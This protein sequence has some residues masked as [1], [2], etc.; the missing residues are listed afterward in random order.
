MARSEMEEVKRQTPEYSL[1]SNM[2]MRFG[3]ESAKACF[4]VLQWRTSPQ[5]RGL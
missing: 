2:A 4:A 1:V 5:G 3:S